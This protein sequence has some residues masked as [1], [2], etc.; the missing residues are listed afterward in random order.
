VPE[1][2]Y[3]EDE[4][5]LILR[6]AVDSHTDDSGPMSGSGMTLEEL[7]DIG[8]EVGIE[9]A[10]IETAA[11]SL[12][13]V[14]SAPTGR[15]L[16]QPTTV[17]FERVIPARLQDEHMPHLLDLIRNEFA[18]QGIVTEVMGG[19]EWKAGG[20]LG[21]RYVSLRPEGDQ[22]RIRVLGNY[23]D[24]FLGLVIGGGS[25]TGMATAAIVGKALAIANP[26]LLLPAGVL[27]VVATST[28]VFRFFFG[29]EQDALERVMGSLETRLLE[30]EAAA[31]GDDD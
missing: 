18:R 27:G 30:F 16:G 11:R 9:S 26:V 8:V 17:Q 7:K 19:F 10:Q 28:P 4:V 3:N 6:K 29:K 1:R 25:V 31:G 5:A 21:T 22:T 20:S 23:R 12:D 15:I 14:R 2:R 24:G 13:V